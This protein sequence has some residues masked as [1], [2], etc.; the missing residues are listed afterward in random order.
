[1]LG[2]DNMVDITQVLDPKK[3]RTYLVSDLRTKTY[4]YIKRKSGEDYNTILRLVT[5]GV[6]LEDIKTFVEL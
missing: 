1:M 2:I 3:G 5:Q 6:A 4:V